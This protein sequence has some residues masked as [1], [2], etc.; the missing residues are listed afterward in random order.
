[1][2]RRTAGLLF[3]GIC[4]ALAILLLTGM[5]TP[6]GG[7]CLFAVALVVFGAMSRGFTN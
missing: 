1:M 2:R 5:L 3:L 4:G 7:G 6:L